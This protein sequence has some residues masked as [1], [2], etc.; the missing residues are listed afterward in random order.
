MNSVILGMANLTFGITNISAQTEPSLQT[1]GSGSGAGGVFELF[2]VLGFSLISLI[3]YIFCSYCFQKI[4][5]R[6]NIPN[7]WLAWVPFGNTWLMLRA[8]D[9]SGWWVVAMFIP[10]LNFV[11]LIFLIIA[12][13]N[14]MKKL[15]RSPWL[16]LLL[17][18][19][20]A[21]FWLMY[22]LA[23]N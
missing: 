22:S 6:L 16:L 4:F 1:S 21:N 3:M 11:V 14:V 12:F 8:G 10:L 19:P 23:F 7:A 15:G 17:L 13:V 5:Q 18:V 20:L 2:W 9:Q